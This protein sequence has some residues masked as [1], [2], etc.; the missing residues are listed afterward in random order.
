MEPREY[1]IC[2]IRYKTKKPL[3][4][5]KHR[6]KG[7]LAVT[8]TFKT[9]T[10]EHGNLIIRYLQH[11]LTDKELDTF[12]AW[13]EEDA[14]HK[15]RYFETKAMY[16]LCAIP[17]NDNIEASWQ[18]L[19]KKRRRHAPTDVSLGRKFLQYAAVAVI[20]V[21]VTSAAFLTF[22]RNTPDVTTQY[23]GGDGLEADVVILPD[24]TR[25]SLGSKTYFRYD[26]NY[27]MSSRIVY[28]EGEA[29]FEVARQQEKPFI[30]KTKVQDIQALGTKFNV[31]AYNSDSL[32]TTTLLE[33]SVQLSTETLHDVTVLTPNQQSVYNK[34]CRQIEVNRVDA[35]RFTSWVNGYYY[36]HKQPL[37]SILQRISH[38]YGVKFIIQSDELKQEPFTGTFYRGQSIK[39]IMGIIQLSVPVRYRINDN[40]IT[41]DK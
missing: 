17:A 27:G 23:I 35:S 15:K 31:M 36:F 20:A 18:R 38:V 26:K 39:D 10:D 28:L 33:G 32:V 19:L 21:L 11:Q 7:R 12:Y 5:A 22:P 1:F 24:D 25:V 2:A 41:I 8:L 30:V 16:D 29:F 37:Q 6:I 4:P 3:P 9:M 40:V 34:N 14:A 13:L